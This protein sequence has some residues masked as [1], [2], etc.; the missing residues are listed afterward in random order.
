MKAFEFSSLGQ[1]A[2]LFFDEHGWVQVRNVFDKTQIESFRKVAKGLES[3]G[4]QGDLLSYSETNSIVYDNH[5]VSI[6]K[7]LLDTNKPVYFGDSNVSIGND[8]HR[9]FH[10]DNADKLNASASDWQSPYTL[11]RMGIYT[12]DHKKHSDCLAIR[13]GSHKTVETEVGK[14]LNIPAEPGDVVIWNLRTSHSGNSNRLRFAP[15]YFLR[16]RYYRIMPDFMFLPRDRE[17]ICFFLTYG[18]EKDQHLERYIRYL[19]TRKYMVDIW[20]HSHYAEEQLTKA[21]TTLEVIQMSEEANNIS[22]EQ[23]NVMHKELTS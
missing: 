6:A 15:N 2:K 20:C 7:L 22:P 23:L 10:K 16:Y 8:F 1:S 9:G 5:L 14:P 3:V 4:H 21:K 13:D 19:K 17:R 12:Q 11:L 18:K